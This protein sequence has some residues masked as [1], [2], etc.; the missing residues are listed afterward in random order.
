MED[1][2]SVRRRGI[3]G[4][5]SLQEGRSHQAPQIEVISGLL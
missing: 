2:R 1:A 4:D 5:E 3:E